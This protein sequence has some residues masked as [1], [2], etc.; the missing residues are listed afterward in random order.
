MSCRISYWSYINNLTQSMSKTWAFRRP[1][2]CRGWR[3]SDV[4]G[5]CC[6]RKML[7]SCSGL[8][9]PQILAS[10]TSPLG[11]GSRVWQ[12]SGLEASCSCRNTPN[13]F[14]GAMENSQLRASPEM[15]RVLQQVQAVVRGANLGY[16]TPRTLWYWRYQFWK[17]HHVE[18]LARLLR[19]C[20]KAMPCGNDGSF[21]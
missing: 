9:Q 19:I 17:R 21:D 2:H 14:P 5:A 8:E 3:A 12:A 11:E 18:F 10:R 6:I 20:H 7:R 16:V 15:E 4:A 13:H 1:R